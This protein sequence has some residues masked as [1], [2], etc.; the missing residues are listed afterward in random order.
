MQ[1][2][3]INADPV[4]VETVRPDAPVLTSNGITAPPYIYVWEGGERNMV[5]R[6]RADRVL[7]IP[8]S[9]PYIWEDGSDLWVE[10]PASLENLEIL[11]CLPYVSESCMVEAWRLIN[12]WG[13]VIP[14]VC[15]MSILM[16]NG[17]CKRPGFDQHLLPAVSRTITT[18]KMRDL[19]GGEAMCLGMGY[20]KPED[21]MVETSV[22]THEVNEEA[23]SFDQW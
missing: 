13:H 15:F 12:Q 11:A 4:G 7:T 18:K 22:T 14:M 10:A 5:R 19:T 23:A 17:A 2:L 21:F 3:L 16:K 9:S 6:K 8:D 1:H 20:S